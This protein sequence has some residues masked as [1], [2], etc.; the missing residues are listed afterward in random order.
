MI[1]A[2]TL[3]KEPLFSGYNRL[4]LL[5]NT[6]LET[7]SKHGWEIH[8]WVVF[9]NHYHIIAKSPDKRFSVQ[10][11]VR[12]LHSV[13]AREINSIDGTPGRR[14]W[15]QY[16]DTCITYE[17]SYYARLRYVMA[18]PVKHGYVQDEFAYPWGCARW[19]EEHL[20]SSALGRIKSYRCDRVR[21]VDNF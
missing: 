15:F 17:Q 3:H 7:F 1:T 6:L 16:W 5:H 19:F 2:G 8:A 21:V 9:S 13:T 10:E 14:V 11:P 4:E 20:P 12:E 18:N